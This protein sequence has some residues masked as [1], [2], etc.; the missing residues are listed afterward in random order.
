MAM[1]RVAARE[2]AIV[3]AWTMA[4]FMAKVLVKLWPGQ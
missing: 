4:R 2:I 3:M 1:A